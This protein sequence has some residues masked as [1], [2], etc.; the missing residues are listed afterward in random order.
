MENITITIISLTS[1]F[2]AVGTLI[3]TLL[4]TQREINDAL[5]KQIRKQIDIDTEIIGRMEIVKEKLSADRVQIFDFH[6]GEYYANGRSALKTTCTYEVVRY[7]VKP[8]RIFLENIPLSVIPRFT[9]KLLD[10]KVFEVSNLND[11]KETMTATYDLKKSQQVKSFY[12]IV[13]QNKD[14]EPIGF[15]AIQFTKEPH[16]KFTQEE[17]TCIYNLKFFIEENLEKLYKKQRRI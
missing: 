2:G 1:L 12:D 4:K 6:N 17:V 8:S 10:D 15:L 11:I 14:G 9:K 13:L 3:L 7:G 5:P 16:K